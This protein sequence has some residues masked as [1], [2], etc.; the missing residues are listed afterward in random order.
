MRTRRS[1]T[2]D[3]GSQ[4]TKLSTSKPDRHELATYEIRL[5]G[6]L[7][8]R[9]AE[10]LDVAGL[11]HE[12]DGATVMRATVAD[13]SALHGL[14]QRIRDLG[15]PLVSV[16]RLLPEQVSEPSSSLPQKGR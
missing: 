5:Q 6:H 4:M 10:Q 14:L 9:W 2:T 8:A 13:Q 12:S 7:D 11:N 15:L 1:R 3:P 16:I